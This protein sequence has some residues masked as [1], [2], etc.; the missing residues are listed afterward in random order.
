MAIK[1]R[2]YLNTP[3]T[4]R[5]SRSSGK[6]DRWTVVAESL[7]MSRAKPAVIASVV[8]EVHARAIAS[9]PGLISALNQAYV[10]LETIDSKY[11]HDLLAGMHQGI[12]DLLKQISKIEDESGLAEEDIIPVSTPFA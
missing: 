8:G 10:V 5:R 1:Q 3:W 6:N 12:Q 7:P 11:G 4:V 2:S 9:L